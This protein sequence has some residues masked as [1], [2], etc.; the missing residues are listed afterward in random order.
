L[1]RT[2]SKLLLFLALCFV[3]IELTYRVYTMGPAALNPAV[4]NS[5]TNILQSG[6]VQPADNR[7]VYFE[8]KPNL[9]TLHNGAVFRTN[10]AGMADREYTR[11]KPPGVFRIAVI[12]SSW[13]MPAGVKNQSAWHALIE[14]EL[15]DGTLPTVE[16]LNFGVELYGLGELVGTLRHK[17]M[18][19]QP[20]LVLVGITSLTAYLRWEPYTSDFVPPPIRRPFWESR[21]AG[22][23]AGMLGYTLYPSVSRPD[24]GADMARDRQQTVRAIETLHDIAAQHDVPLAIVWLG[25]RPLLQKQKEAVIAATNRLHVPLI[26]G[27][28]PITPHHNVPWGGKFGDV[29]YQVSRFDRHPNELGHEL[30][31]QQV[32]HDLRTFQLLPP[33]KNK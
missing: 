27:Y 26:L 17:V 2:I 23:L 4:M 24:L 21:V 22:A 19:W 18:D 6:L 32:L 25:F 20:D 30:M 3:A 33:N 29:R 13:T 31:A 7:E 9:D 28:K 12:G 1:I 15:N 14:N 5:M 8:L 10:S 11:E 16:V